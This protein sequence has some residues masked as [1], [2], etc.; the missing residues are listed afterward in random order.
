MYLQKL[1]YIDFGLLNYKSN[2]KFFLA[3]MKCHHKNNKQTSFIPVSN[4]ILNSAHD[5]QISLYDSSKPMVDSYGIIHLRAH[6]IQCGWNLSH[7][8][9][10]HTR[11]ARACLLHPRRSH[12]TAHLDEPPEREKGNAKEKEN[13]LRRRG[14]AALSAYAQI[15][16]SALQIILMP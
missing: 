4:W 13:L 11:V 3:V 8:V 5:A 7:L 1:P 16:V 2:R 6:L 12:I 14:R 9:I 10:Q 15:F